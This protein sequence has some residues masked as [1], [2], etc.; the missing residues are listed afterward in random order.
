MLKLGGLRLFA[1]RHAG[2]IG[3]VLLRL[4]RIQFRLFSHPF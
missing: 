3:L 4:I 1:L 2:Q